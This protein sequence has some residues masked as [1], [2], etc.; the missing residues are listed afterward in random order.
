MYNW[1]FISALWL[2]I[3]GV[4]SE[5]PVAENVLQIKTIWRKH[6]WSKLPRAGHVQDEV[7][8]WWCWGPAA[9]AEGKKATSFAHASGEEAP[10]GSLQKATVQRTFQDR[11]TKLPCQRLQWL[12]RHLWVQGLACQRC[13][14]DGFFGHPESTRNLYQIL[15]LETNAWNQTIPD[16]PMVHD[17]P[18]QAKIL[19]KI[20]ESRP[21]I[22]ALRQCFQGL[23]ELLEAKR[24]WPWCN[25]FFGRSRSLTMTASS[26]RST[27]PTAVVGLCIC[28]PS[29]RW[30]NHRRMQAIDNDWIL[31]AINTAA[32][33]ALLPPA[34]PIFVGSTCCIPTRTC[35][36]LGCNFLANHGMD[37]EPYQFPKKPRKSHKSHP[38]YPLS[39]CHPALM[40]WYSAP[41]LQCKFSRCDAHCMPSTRPYGT[42]CIMI[43]KIYGRR[44]ILG[45]TM[46]MILLVSS[47][48]WQ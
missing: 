8:V 44:G 42:C 20:I 9:K 7:A 48:R 16:A 40:G 36:R 17:G 39:H 14:R 33:A 12:E 2:L 45:I 28:T 11:T 24:W 21:G 34:S 13:N 46:A 10:H 35:S 29:K 4:S 19:F 41:L 5:S 26:Q 47:I 15:V 18:F 43:A 1:V 27:M 32:A 25:D 3:V 31:A 38:S 6:P 30:T 23:L 22:R 37:E